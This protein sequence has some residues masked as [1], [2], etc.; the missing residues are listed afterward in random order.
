MFTLH[1][2]H[3]P[4]NFLCWHEKISSTVQMI[5]ALNWKQVV[6]THQTSY[7]STVFVQSLEFLK[8]TWNLPSYF[9]DMEK[10]WKMEKK[11]GI[12]VKSLEFFFSKLIRQ[13]FISE[14]FRVGQILF[15]LAPTFAAHHEKKIFLAFFKVSVDHELFDNLESGKRSYCFGKKSWI[16]DLKSV[17]THQIVIL[18]CEYLLPS[19]VGFSPFSY[20]FMLAKRSTKKNCNKEWHKHIWS[21]WTYAVS[22]MV[23]CQPKS[24]PVQTEHGLYVMLEF[25]NL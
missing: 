25:P 13:D 21:V 7:Q 3:L 9:P 15:N 8:K 24:Y 20:S 10:V 18:L 22:D 4:D 2:S 1:T 5:T 6:H 14:I 19:L 12:M 23:S 17:L 11:S 16:L